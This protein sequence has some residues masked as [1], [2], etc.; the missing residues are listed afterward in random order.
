MCFVYVSE[1]SKYSLLS[2]VIRNENSLA[3][4][5]SVERDRLGCSGTTS[6]QTIKTLTVLSESEFMLLRAM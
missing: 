1:Q 3:T 4:R 2:I 5:C 6:Y